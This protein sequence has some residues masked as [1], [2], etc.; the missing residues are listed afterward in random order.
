MKIENF[1]TTVI[2]AEEGNY[3]TQVADVDIKERLIVKTVALGRYD[4]ADNWK[5]IPEHEAQRIIEEQKLAM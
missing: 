3:L 5:E 2:N 1:T 4:S